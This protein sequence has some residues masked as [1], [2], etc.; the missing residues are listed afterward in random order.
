VRVASLGFR[1]D[2]AVLAL[3]G[4]EI[5][6]RGDVIVVRTPRNPYYWWGNFLLLAGLPAP[7]DCRRW[8]ARFAVEFPD[9]DHL[10]LGIDAPDATA[11]DAAWFADH[12]CAVDL[13]TVLT[14]DTV[15]PPATVHDRATL[16][17]L[18]SDDDW[19]RS[20]DLEVRSFAE[21][22][23]DPHRVEFAARRIEANRRL[24][25]AGHGGWFGAFLAE[26]LV[27]QLGLVD[28]GDGLARFQAVGTDPDFRRQ[29][30]AG[31]LV[32]H[33]S[34]WGFD[35]LGARTL[36]IVADPDHFAIELYRKVGFTAAGTQLR[37]ERAPT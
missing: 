37:I 28:A 14:A 24:V 35:V 23:H 9:A 8:L 27:A 12:G 21:E 32:H 15:H 11:A 22:A 10:A 31:T 29:G 34:C 36:V 20:V 13:A 2:L 26:R 1:T 6:D 18:T 25:E 7:E 30:L 4:S 17:L 3:D 5:V 19:A 16:R 33:A